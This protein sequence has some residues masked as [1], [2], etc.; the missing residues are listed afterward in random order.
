MDGPPV[1]APVEW[2]PGR[3]KTWAR[4][5]ALGSTK[6]SAWSTTPPATSSAVKTRGT[7]GRPAASAL[8]QKS[9]RPVTGG[10]VERSQIAWQPLVND[11]AEVPPARLARHSSWRRQVERSTTV[12]WQ[13]PSDAQ[14]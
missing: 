5:S 6:R 4:M 2:V 13:S 8:V 1:V 14:A 3:T 11:P 9:P 10:T 12:R 7:M